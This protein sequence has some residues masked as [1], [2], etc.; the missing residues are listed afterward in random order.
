MHDAVVDAARLRADGVDV[1]R[2]VDERDLLAVE[3][4]ERLRAV[5]ALAFYAQLVGSG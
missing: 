4:D 2:G 5:A 1:L 3:Y